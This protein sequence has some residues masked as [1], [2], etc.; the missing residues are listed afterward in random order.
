MAA[1]LA[2]VE[3][4]PAIPAALDPR[5]RDLLERMLHAEPQNRPTAAEVAAAAGALA[6][7]SGAVDV[8]APGTTATVPLTAATLVAPAPGALVGGAAAGAGASPPPATPAER[9]TPA[10]G[11]RPARLLAIIGGALAAVAVVIA[12]VIGALAPGGPQDTPA[13]VPAVTDP[14]DTP[15][16]AEDT[17]NDTVVDDP[18]MTKEERKAAEEAQK[19][20]EEAQKKLEEEQRKQAEE[21]QKRLEE[22]KKQ[23][24]DEQGHD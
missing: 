2:R 21:E 20:A 11:A 16:P 3:N 1:A 24:D 7:P 4:P 18:G 23:D 6:D 8:S 22:Q 5:W 17:G 14:S 19:E 15:T 13:P 10:R 9:G 12:V